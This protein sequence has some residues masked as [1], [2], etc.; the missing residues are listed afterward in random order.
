VPAFKPFE[1]S[2]LP[3]FLLACLP[4]DLSMRETSQIHDGK[5][6]DFFSRTVFGC[7]Q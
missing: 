5:M 3:D 2:A 1:F 7:L 6:S 4:R